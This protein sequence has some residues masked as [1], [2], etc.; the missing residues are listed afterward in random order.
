MEQLIEQL[1]KVL[2]ETFAFY[3]KTQ[4]F[5]WNVEGKDFYADH[6]FFQAIYEE[7][8]GAIDPIAEHIRTLDGYAAG[9]FTRYAQLSSIKD[10]VQVVQGLEQFQILNSDNEKLK[11]SLNDARRMADKF[12]KVGLSNFLQD[13][14]DAHEKHGWMLRATFKRENA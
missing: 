10:Q 1:N 2:A 13:R 11:V 8:Y 12:N 5:H 14:I 9:S 4:F 3:L 6:T 7:V